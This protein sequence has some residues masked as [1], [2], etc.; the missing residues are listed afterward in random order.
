ME[1]T[2]PKNN[3][4]NFRRGQRV[5]FKEKLGKLIFVGYQVA[6]FKSDSGYIFRVLN[7]KDL[8]VIK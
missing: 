7:P 3:F 1:Q 6:H 8:H 2:C 5:L 4:D